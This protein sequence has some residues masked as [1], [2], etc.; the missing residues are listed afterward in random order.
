MAI[1]FSTLSNIAEL[2]TLAPPSPKVHAV[3]TSITKLLL[4]GF[5]GGLFVL[6][7]WT[8][9]FGTTLLPIKLVS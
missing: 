3:F 2:I 7:S 8:V 6:F 1:H 4:V 5:L 9:Y